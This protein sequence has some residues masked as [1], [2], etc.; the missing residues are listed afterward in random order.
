MVSLRDQQLDDAAVY[1]VW[2]DWQRV[3]VLDVARNKLRSLPENVDFPN[4][5]GLNASYNHI[6]KLPN[7][8]LL[9]LNLVALDLSHNSLRSLPENVDAP[10][11]ERLY[12]SHNNIE[13]IPKQIFLLPKLVH[14][15]L[16]NNSLHALPDDI[17]APTLE[18][19]H[20]SRNRIITL[21]KRILLF[22]K[23]MQLD[24]S[25]NKLQELPDINLPV[26]AEPEIPKNEAEII[27][28]Q[29][30]LPSLLSLDLSHNDL[31]DV[32]AAMK[33]LCSPS[34][35]LKSVELR[36]NAKQMIVPPSKILE[37]G[38]DKVC[39]FFKDLARGQKLCWSQTVLVVGQEEAG[40][41]A[42]CHALS[43]HRCADHAQTTE[44]STVG[45][46]T[47]HWSTVVAIP[48]TNRSNRRQSQHVLV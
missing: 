22:P 6:K 30:Y 14:I 32:T 42:L 19:L 20:L 21:P 15:D 16:S 29:R 25:H 26:L 44:A 24:L 40:K 28:T 3:V 43:G 48:R 35:K 4:L 46:D 38:G 10:T 47:V 27:P 13:T 11:L 23:L 8:P 41:T 7:Q 17:D 37:S 2:Q 36:G 45:I 1:S 31:R 18:R 34:S 5:R 33:Q 12:L 39:Q 9:L